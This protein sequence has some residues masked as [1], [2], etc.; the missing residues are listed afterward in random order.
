MNWDQRIAKAEK[1]GHF[2]INDR[3]ASGNWTKCSVGENF[4][5]RS[6]DDA[7]L[8]IEGKVTR[9]GIKFCQSVVDGEIKRA[10]RLHNQIKKLA[11]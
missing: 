1:N 5:I 9:L 8:V 10:K 7:R 3:L 6:L 11:K 4:K 2:T